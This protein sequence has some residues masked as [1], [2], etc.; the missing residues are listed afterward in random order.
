MRAF[1]RK[2]TAGFLVMIQLMSL[3]THLFHVILY[4]NIKIQLDV[5]LLML[6]AKIFSLTVSSLRHMFSNYF[7]SNLSVNSFKS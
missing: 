1:K 4:N 3:F 6:V 5:C 2:K 7:F